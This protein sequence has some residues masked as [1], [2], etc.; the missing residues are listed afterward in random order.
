MT[1]APPAD[2]IKI[3]RHDAVLEITLDRPKANAIN[4][5][6][7]RRLGEAF[8]EFRDD[9]DLRVA[10]VSSFETAQRRL[11]EHSERQRG[12]VKTH[13]EKPVARV[14]RIFPEEGYAHPANYDGA[15]VFVA[16][17]QVLIF[18]PLPRRTHPGNL[19]RP[20]AALLCLQS[21]GGH[22]RVRLLPLS[23]GLQGGR[24][25]LGDPRL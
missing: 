13:F 12:E 19:C 10:I 2:P 24:N 20:A 14:V 3:A 11:K 6:M 22:H 16:G 4:P 23:W 5:L 21:P 17:A 25:G 8:A 15:G 18:R 7:S 9:P 1:D